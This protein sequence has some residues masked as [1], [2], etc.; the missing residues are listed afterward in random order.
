MARLVG[1]AKSPSEAHEIASQ[2]LRGR[3]FR[4]DDTVFLQHARGEGALEVSGGRL[5]VHEAFDGRDF[6]VEP[7]DRAVDVA[8]RLLWS[9]HR[10]A[11]PDG[12]DRF[13]ALFDARKAWIEP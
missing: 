4:R 8:A 11:L 2:A 5:V 7:L 3:A 6:Q 10:G 1:A 12:A 9:H 13:A